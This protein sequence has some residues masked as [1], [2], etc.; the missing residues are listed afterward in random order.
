MKAQHGGKRPGAGRK[1]GSKSRATKQAK[2][3]FA[4]LAKEYSVEALEVAA[5]IMRDAGATPSSRI[6]AVN[7]IL[8][9]AY[10]KAAQ[11]VTMSG[12]GGGPVQ[13][14]D[15]SKMTTGAMRE[16]I[17]AMSEASGTIDD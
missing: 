16:L 1:P 12:E 6:A 10:G 7:T 13:I 8:D 5:E 15:P 4:E 9:R 17:E 2:M 11:A 3:T 14:V